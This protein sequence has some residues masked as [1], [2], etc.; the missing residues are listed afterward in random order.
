MLDVFSTREIAIGIYLL[1]I[2]I[3]VFQEK[4]ISPAAI[5]VIKYALSIKLVIPFIVI[6]M[7]SGVLCI[8]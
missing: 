4:K 5:N 8:P 2:I 6:L 3:F 1:L 7:Y